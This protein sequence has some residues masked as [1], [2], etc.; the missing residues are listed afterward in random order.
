MPLETGSSK[1]A[2]SHNVAELVKAG[3]KQ[4]QALAIAYKEKEGHDASDGTIKAAGIMYIEDNSVLLLKRLDGSWAFPGGKIEQGEKAI[5]AARRESGEEVGFVPAHDLLW[6]IDYSNNGRVQFTTYCCRT[7]FEP[8]LNTDE[9]SEFRWFDF[10]DL[11]DIMHPN[12]RATLEKYTK[13]YMGVGLDSA[14]EADVN[15]WIEIKDNPISKAGVFEYLG[16]QIDKD[17]DPDKVYRVLRSPE[18]LSK[19]ETID[20]FKLVPWIDEHVMLGPADS[21]MVAPEL[22]GIEGVTGETVYFDLADRKL[23]SN[24][25]VFSN[26][27]D[28]LI[29]G[30]KREL[31]LGYRC[32]Y[33]IS[34]G[35]WEGQ[36]YDVVQHDIR[37]NH[38]ALV[39]EGRMG[40]DVAVLD[41][42]QF[43]FD[44]R[45]IMAEADLKKGMDDLK[46]IVE[47]GFKAYDSK[48]EALDKKVKDSLEDEDG[49]DESEK[50][51]AEDKKAADKK[52]KDE[53]E[54]KEKKDKDAEDRKAMDAAI[55]S[56]MDGAI[57]P[58]QDT[59]N[60][61]QTAQNAGQELGR[62][63][64]LQSQLATYGVAV[65]SAEGLSL[66]DLQT[67]AVEKLGLSCPK[68]SEGVALDSYFT[69]RAVPGDEIGY[70]M[71]AQTGAGT[72]KVLDTFFNGKAA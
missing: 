31:S 27:L 19:K 36:Q 54:E 57:K 30:G 22:K 41:H 59:I 11:P 17:L 42:M 16:R 62:K 69:N 10:G 6:E 23:K 55:R 12:A 18:E 56:A 1:E 52:T 60:A 46:K 2:F 14:R 26:N 65:D 24:I 51:E 71:D 9:H 70:A 72:G 32:K 53:A 38:L 40:P 39:K 34:A 63:R 50:K 47:D 20:S 37:G 61:L 4:S 3:H 64:A 15:G 43:T 66:V 58:L 5:D 45:D 25:K 29:A 21:G 33:K 8:I 48:I 35:V 44:A 7:G 68:G 28:A 13:T 67:K 49:M